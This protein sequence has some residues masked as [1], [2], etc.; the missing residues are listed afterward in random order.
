MALFGDTGCQNRK[1]IS[2]VFCKYLRNR[3]LAH[4][5]GHN[6]FVSPQT[7]FT[8]GFVTFLKTNHLVS[9]ILQGFR[10]HFKSTDWCGKE[11]KSKKTL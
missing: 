2:Y 5:F 1:I 11:G 8:L 7:Y 9:R 6:T 10:K 3:L 4:I